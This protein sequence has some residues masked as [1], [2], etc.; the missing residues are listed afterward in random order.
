MI[1]NIHSKINANQLSLYRSVIRY[2][3]YFS[4]GIHVNF[5][6]PII[7]TYR[8]RNV[9]KIREPLIVFSVLQALCPLNRTRLHVCELRW[10][11]LHI[12]RLV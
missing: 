7:A 2:V 8:L 9:V 6:A 3:N 5:K 4:G 11:V 10:E 1:S 12:S